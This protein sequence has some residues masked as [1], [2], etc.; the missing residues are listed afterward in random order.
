MSLNY[1]RCIS[2]GKDEED[3]RPLFENFLQDLLVTLNRPDWPAAEVLLTLLGRLLVSKLLLLLLLL[4]RICLKMKL[5]RWMLLDKTFSVIFALK[6][7]FSEVLPF[8]LVQVYQVWVGRGRGRAH[9]LFWYSPNFDYEI[10]VNLQPL[11]WVSAPCSQ[12]VPIPFPPP[13]VT[14]IL[15]LLPSCT[16]LSYADCDFQQQGKWC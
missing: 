7:E 8:L 1:C 3:Y 11:S 4:L 14:T 15:D 6:V 5:C 16:I 13:N 12:G 2:V 10:V 9:H